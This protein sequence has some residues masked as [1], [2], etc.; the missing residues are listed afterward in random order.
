MI[1][2]SYRLDRPAS[3]SCPDCG[4]VMT[5]E[6]GTPT[7]FYRC[8]IGHALTIETLLHA[9]HHVLEEKLGACLALLNE[10]AELCRLMGEATQREGREASRF[11]AAR[12]QSLEQAEVVR[13]LLENDWFHPEEGRERLRPEA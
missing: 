8:H 1:P 2:D 10:R 4:G 5:R 9:K 3:I 12:E 7:I 11:V 13:R 6:P